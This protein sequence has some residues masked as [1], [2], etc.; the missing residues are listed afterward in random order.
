LLQR[1]LWPAAPPTQEGT[2]APALLCRSRWL[3]WPVL[4]AERRG[5]AMSHGLFPIAAAAANTSLLG[6]RLA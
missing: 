6:S 4:L 3:L 1:A 5:P 2:S